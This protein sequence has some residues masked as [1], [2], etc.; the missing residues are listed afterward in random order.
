MEEI[1]GP[2]DYVL[3]T[4]SSTVNN[5]VS[6]YGTEILEGTKL[7]SIGPITTKAI[8][9]QGLSLAGQSE[10]ATIP[11]MVAWIKEDVKNADAKNS[12]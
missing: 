11:S 8:E 3:F 6:H 7:V 5:F 1:Q 4:S 12:K 10:K 2:L 9:D